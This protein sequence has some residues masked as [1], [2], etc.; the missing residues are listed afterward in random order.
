MPILSHARSTDHLSYATCRSGE[1]PQ[2]LAS[3]QSVAALL[4]GLRVVTECRT[5]VE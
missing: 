2:W 3:G 1:D 5:Q 4:E